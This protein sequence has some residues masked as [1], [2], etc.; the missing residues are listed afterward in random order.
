LFRWRVT[1]AEEEEERAVIEASSWPRQ[2]RPV[3]PRVL[4]SIKIDVN[5]MGKMK[6]HLQQAF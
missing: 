5:I 1:A 6:Q 3:S 4:L 2:S